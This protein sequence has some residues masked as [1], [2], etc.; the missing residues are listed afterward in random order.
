MNIECIKDRLTVAVGRAERITGKNLSLPIL[1]CVLLEAKNNTLTVRATN[2]EIGVEITIPV[3]VND[4][5]VVAVPGTVLFSLLTALQGEKNISV[6]LEDQVLVVSSGKS[7]A[8][9]AIQPHADFPTLPGVD[10]NNRFLLPV[11]DLVEGIH[12]VLFASSNSTVKPEYA[13]VFIHGEQDTLTF[14]A[15]DSFR[16]AEKKI[17]CKRK[18]DILSLLLPNK[19]AAEIAR[20]ASDVGGDVTIDIDGNQISFSFEGVYITSRLIDGSFPDY[21]QIIPKNTATEVIALKQDFLQTMKVANV[22]SDSFMQVSLSVSP[23]RKMFEIKTKNAAVGEQTT[24]LPAAFTGEEVAMNFNHRYIVDCFPS[25]KADNISFEFGGVG[26]PLV[27]KGTSDK[28]F[29]YLVMPMNR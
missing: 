10:K 16:L 6:R 18:G 24:Q 29:T 11:K 12:S 25:V 2:L 4:E 1:S 7:V 3:K 8:S 14:V 17:Y 28:T 21:K 23:M 26:K 20:I 27:I 22:F 5:G 13:S 19:N 9:V 15:T